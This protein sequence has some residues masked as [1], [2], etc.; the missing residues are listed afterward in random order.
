[1]SWPSSQAAIAS[2]VVLVTG[3]STTSPAGRL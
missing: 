3:S 1:M 2:V